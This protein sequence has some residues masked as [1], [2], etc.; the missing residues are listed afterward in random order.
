VPEGSCRI[1][2][3]PMASHD[4]VDIEDCIL[5]FREAGEHVG[6]L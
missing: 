3:S 5:A 4:R 1:R 2:V 6:L